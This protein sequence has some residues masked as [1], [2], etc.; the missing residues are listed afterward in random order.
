MNME[1]NSPAFW[2]DRLRASALHL[3]L[4]LT[5]AAL[6]AALVFGVWYPYPYR[7]ISGGR[8]LFLILV[9]VDVILG[10]FLTLAVFNR[11]K[12]WPVLR[13][14]LVVIALLQLTALGYGLWTVFVARPVHMVF[15]Y[16][17]FAV[18]HAVELT[19]EELK[20]APPAI[21]A[22]PL[23]GPTLLS[24]R[25]I[26]NESEKVDFTLAAVAGVGL[27]ARPELW[28]PYAKALPEILKEAKPVRALKNRFANRA[29][30]IDQV[31]TRAGGNPQTALYLPLIGRDHYWTVFVDPIDA[32]IVATMPLDPF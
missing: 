17:R 25:E 14:D 11:V 24:L 2:R 18:V 19:P 5:I 23:T 10:P 7:E 29:L 21:D 27:V 15:E 31:V 6:A 22:L 4:S 3:T 12:A 26:K 16:N 9:T 13:R 1:S 20:K 32:H 8:E 28:Q 30:E